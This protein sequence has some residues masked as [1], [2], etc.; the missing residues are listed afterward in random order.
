MREGVPVEPF[1]CSSCAVPF[2]ERGQVHQ[3]Q[4]SLVDLVPVDAHGLFLVREFS[5]ANDR[6]PFQRCLPA[7]RRVPSTAGQGSM[8]AKQHHHA[9][10]LGAAAHALAR[11]LAE[12]PVG[13]LFKSHRFT[14]TTALLED[15]PYLPVAKMANEP[16][17]RSWNA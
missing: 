5:L 13:D 14:P 10:E 8:A 6:V 16:R 2:S 9:I 4:R 7:F 12:G 3:R 17:F 11:R 15:S 1:P